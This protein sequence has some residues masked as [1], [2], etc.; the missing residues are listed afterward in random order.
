MEHSAHDVTP[1]ANNRLQEEVT[2]L[3]DVNQRLRSVLEERKKGY[4]EQLK[5]EQEKAQRVRCRLQKEIDELIDRHEREVAIWKEMK[6]QYD[7]A[8]AIYKQENPR[9]RGGADPSGA[10]KSIHTHRGARTKHS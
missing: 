4:E 7:Q 8:V 6:E 2:K 3:E 9:E 5:H 1:S 10:S